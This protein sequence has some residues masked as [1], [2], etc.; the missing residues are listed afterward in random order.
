MFWLDSGRFT[1]LS[2][3][4]NGGGKLGGSSVGR[5]LLADGDCLTKDG[6]E[7]RRSM[8]WLD[9]GRF[10]PLSKGSN[11]GGKLGG[12]SVGC[13]LLL[14]LVNDGDC[15]STKDGGGGGSCALF[16]LGR[17]T[18]AAAGRI[19]S[20]ALLFSSMVAGTEVATG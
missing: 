17:S 1:P 4:S 12:S 15:L 6:C 16:C 7:G 2:M 13:C 20:S 11:G 10:R 9:S 5:C 3:G 14:L 18:A 8:F 19:G